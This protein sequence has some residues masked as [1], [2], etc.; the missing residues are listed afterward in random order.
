MARVNLFRIRGGNQLLTDAFSSRLG[1][2]SV[3][4]ARLPKSN[5]PREE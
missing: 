4:D 3:W 5:I 1:D 2:R